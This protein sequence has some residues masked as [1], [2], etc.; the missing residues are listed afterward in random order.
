[1]GSLER[2][3]KLPPIL[4]FS[5]FRG[6]NEVAKAE[7]LQALGQ[8][9]RDKGFFQLTNHGV[10]HELQRRI[11]VASKELFDLPLEEKLKAKLMPGTSGRGYETI[12]GQ[13]LEPGSAPDTK[14]AIYLG[15]DLPADH[16]RVLNGEYGCG[17]NIYP[18][19]LGPQWHETCMEYFQAMNTLARDVMRALAAALN[20]PEDYFDRFTDAEPTA[21]L[22][23]VHYPPTPTTSDK[24]R[25]CGAHR[26]FGCI[27]LLL[28]DEVGGLQVQDEETG[29]FLDVEPVPGAYVVNLGNLMARWTNHHYTSNTHRVMNHSPTDRYSVPFF[30]SGNAKYTLETIP[31]LEQRPQQAVARKYGP[32]IPSEPYGP[33]SVAEFLRDQFVQSYKRADD[34][35]PQTIGARA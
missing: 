34:Y 17:S 6:E 26:D 32:A 15:E 31:G 7:F 33:V 5:A 29:E 11:F 14:E 35:R 4:D 9:C 25:G 3:S 2:E 20:I 24:E 23:L 12:G 28:Q 16:R 30:Y 22:R 21:T 10:D 18:A 8:A 19:C 13:M 1:M 27:T